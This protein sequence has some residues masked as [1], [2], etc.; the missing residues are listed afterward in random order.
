MGQKKECKK[1]NSCLATGR[2]SEELT[3]KSGD[4]MSCCPRCIY[5]QLLDRLSCAHR[6]ALLEAFPAEYRTPLCRPE[7]YSGFLAALRTVGFCFRAHLQSACD[8]WPG[9]L[10]ASCFA[11]F[12]SLRFV[13]ETFVGEKHLLAGSKYK[14]GA[15]LRTL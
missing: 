4:R 10:G 14:L 9:T 2:P 13:F 3:K 11:P 6:P 15:A 7:R 1:L 5:Y 8:A 12:T